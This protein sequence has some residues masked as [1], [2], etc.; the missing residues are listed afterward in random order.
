MDVQDSARSAWIKVL[1]LLLCLWDLCCGQTSYSVLEEAKKGIVRN[2]AKDQT[3]SVQEL[4][5]RMFDW[6]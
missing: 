6:I 1:L 5:M 3:L 4:E 2:L